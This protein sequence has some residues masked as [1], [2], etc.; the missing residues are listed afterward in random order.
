MLDAVE[1]L[2]RGADLEPDFLIDVIAQQQT[3]VYTGQFEASSTVPLLFD[4]CRNSRGGV[5]GRQLSVALPAS[6]VPNASE[7]AQVE[8]VLAE[9]MPSVAFPNSNS[10]TN[11]PT[12][13]N[14][15]GINV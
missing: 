7:Q 6:S 8:A 12:P 9:L 13:K 11:P 15:N 4:E 2:E 1:T 14:C 3:F 5:V 10:K